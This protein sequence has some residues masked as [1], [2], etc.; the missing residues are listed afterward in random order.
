MGASM[1]IMKCNLFHNPNC[2]FLAFFFFVFL[3]CCFSFFFPNSRNLRDC[4]VSVFKNSF[5]VLCVSKTLKTFL[6]KRGLSF[7]C[8][9]CVSKNPS[10]QRTPIWGSLCFQKLFFSRKVF[11]NTNQTGAYILI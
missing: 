9:L 10:F 8:V 4:L 11:K 5:C 2:G 1:I 7:L 3:S 6:V